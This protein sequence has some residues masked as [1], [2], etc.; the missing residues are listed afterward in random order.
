[1]RPVCVFFLILSV[2]SLFSFFSCLGEDCITVLVTNSTSEP[3][4]VSVTECW[5]LKVTITAGK[6]G[7]IIV[8]P[9]EIVEAK[10]ED[11]SETYHHVFS[12]EYEI[13]E[14]K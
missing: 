11:L 12:H 1:M 7:N 13:W 2:F 14:M 5:G 4:I 3:I 8:L 9:G 6:S 10:Q